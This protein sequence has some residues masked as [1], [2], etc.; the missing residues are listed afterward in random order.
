MALLHLIQDNFN[1]NTLDTTLWTASG[2]DT[3]KVKEQ[4][5]R[6]E[7]SHAANAE[8]NTLTTA[9]LY[10]MTGSSA[11]VQVI[12]AGDMTI[13]SHQVILGI[14]KDANNAIF[15]TAL[16]GQLQAYKKV[17]GVTTQI[18]SNV[19]YSVVDHLYWRM[20][21]FAGTIFYDTSPDG[22]TWTNRWSVANPFA[23]TSVTAYLQSGCFAVETVASFGY[24][25]NFNVLATTATIEKSYS[26][27]MYRGGTYLGALPNVTSEFNL[28]L[29][30]NSTFAQITVEVGISPDTSQETVTPLLDELGN[31]LLD[32]QGNTLYEER[33]PD[34]FGNENGKAL[35]RNGN[36][37]KVYEYSDSNPNGQIVFDGFIETYTASYSNNNFKLLCLSNGADLG[38]YVVQVGGYTLQMDETGIPLTSSFDTYNYGAGLYQFWGQAFAVVTPFS[39]K[40]ILLK[41]GSVYTLHSTAIVSI[42][43]GDI[44]SAAA[45]A[46]VSVSVVANSDLSAIFATAVPLPAGTYFISVEA[47]ADGSDF[48]V[49]AGTDASALGYRLKAAFRSWGFLAGPDTMLFALY[50]SSALTDSAFSATDPTSILKQSIDNYVAQGGSVNYAT[51]STDLTTLSATYTFKLASVLDVIKKC[52]DLS[53]YDWYFRVDPATNI[54]YFKQTATTATHTLIKG[55]HFEHFDFTATLEDVRNLVYLSGGATAGV[56]LFT[57]YINQTSITAIGRQKLERISDNRVTLQATADLEGNALLNEKAA[58]SYQTTIT[59]LASAYNINTI[60]PGHTITLTGHGNFLDRLVLQIA[61]VVYSGSKADLTLGRLPPRQTAAL[62]QALDNVVALQTIANPSAPS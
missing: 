8:Y 51:G 31:I 9:A 7:I 40:K 39:L 17:A 49:K 54:I 57:K 24:F 34:L 6:L 23:I 5:Q 28:P 45:L 3:T 50:S 43:A 27:R 4:N 60:K 55:R 36:L 10:D 21:E 30:I 44:P 11:Q 29:D 26:Y 46:S 25:D 20:R 1:D 41:I 38:E 61:R 14:A 18:G 42:Y 35:I 62:A 48:D 12:S 58:E 33:V 13:V 19:P 15:M 22:L 47:P 53:P 2:G 16:N 37:I 56:N 32:E 59:V 52:L